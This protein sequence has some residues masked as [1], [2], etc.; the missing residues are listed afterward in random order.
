MGLGAESE[1]VKDN[2]ISGAGG[3]DEEGMF[4]KAG[5]LGLVGAG[6]FDTMADTIMYETWHFAEPIRVLYPLVFPADKPLRYIFQMLDL[7]LARGSSARYG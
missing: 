7:P 4:G 2:E 3:W 5:R 6:D 1:A